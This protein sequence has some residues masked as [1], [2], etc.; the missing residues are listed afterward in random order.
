MQQHGC[1]W[2]VP[3]E[4]RASDDDEG[5]AQADEDVDINR[6]TAQPTEANAGAEAA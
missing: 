1:D 4:R 3:A 2:A 6:A 5:P